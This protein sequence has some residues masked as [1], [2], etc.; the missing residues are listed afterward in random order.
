MRLDS[1][2]VVFLVPKVHGN[3]LNVVA[4]TQLG[5]TCSE[6]ST[7]L[8]SDSSEQ[9]RVHWL[10]FVLISWSSVMHRNTQTKGLP[11]REKGPE[12]RVAKHGSTAAKRY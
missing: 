6:A 5:P 9:T 12:Q 1:F 4:L 3:I 8:A 10:C 7:F 11:P 2:L